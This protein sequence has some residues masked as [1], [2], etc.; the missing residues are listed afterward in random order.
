MSVIGFVPGPDAAAT[1][2]GW[3]RALAGDDDEIE[4]LCLETRFGGRTEQAVRE[5]LGETGEPSPNLT[6]IRDPMPVPVVVERARKS[7]A[8]L[9]VTCQFELPE[10][11]GKAQTSDELIRSSP[12]R[13]FVTLYGEKHPSAVEKI[14]FVAT[15]RAHDRTALRLVDG[16]RQSRKAGVTVAL[17]ED[18]TGAKAGQVGDRTI[19]SLLH[20][21]ALDPEQYEIKVVVDRLKHRGILHCF[22]D[23][24]LVVVGVDAARHVRPLAQSLGEATVAIVKRIPPLRLRALPEWLPRINPSDHADL[25]HDLRQ[26]SSWGPDFVGM[27]GLASAIASLGLLQNSPAVVIGSMLLAP[28]MTPMLGL[29]LALGQANTRLMRLCGKSIGLGFLL[30]LGVSY[31]IGII[32]PSG[33]TLPEEVLSRGGPNV[34]DLLI[35]LFAA[36]AAT[37]AMAR[38]NI[39]GAVA[40]V[41]IA[42]ALVPPVCAAGISLAN[43]GLRTALGA[44][45]LFFTNLVAMIVA[46]S[47]TFS[48]LGITAARALPR[49]RRLAQ[50]G[51][52]SLV[53]V[54]LV[55]F[56]PLSA[57]LVSQI[58]EGK[59]VAAAYPVT[60]A[61]ARA[62]N[63]K[64][65]R[66]PG[67][68]V[69]FMARPRAQPGV[70]I[71]I[72]SKHGLPESY[73]D[74]LRKIVREEMGNPKLPVHVFAVRGWWRSDADQSAVDP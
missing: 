31:L 6:V 8:N 52:M 61:V 74:E 39:S 30:T 49:H 14:L 51:R 67:V 17:I 70:T 36:V 28:L 72:A 11:D 23:H 18:E 2:V 22:E 19:R 53:V 40:G 26:G 63:E 54:L 16:L 41:A 12:C 45:V 69:L 47:F 62:V 13:S 68:E 73:A 37:F 38:P 21:T 57:T 32:T 58:G 9:L 42:T 55:L 65:D 50:L 5:A 46:S 33:A 60:R 25:L 44:G 20:D 43:G 24:D 66:D 3:T 7:V 34:L 27:L 4:L 1:V 71:H 56:G 15:G 10:V 35:A 64:V 48:L 29:G 59:S